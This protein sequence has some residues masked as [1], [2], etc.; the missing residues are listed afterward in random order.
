MIWYCSAFDFV[1]LM[2]FWKLKFLVH[3]MWCMK[4]KN[5]V[6]CIYKYTPMFN[7]VINLK[8]LFEMLSF[9]SIYLFPS[10][11]FKSFLCTLKIFFNLKNFLT[12]IYFNF[13]HPTWLLYLYLRCFDVTI[14]FFFK[15]YW[16]IVF[17]ITLL[18]LL[19]LMKET[20]ILLLLFNLTEYF[21]FVVYCRYNYTFCFQY[22]CL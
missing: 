4:I 22:I 18:V 11:F 3:I 15:F 13:F 12:T 1:F 7:F 9:Y 16:Q 10:Q 6:Y 21:W 17:F 5:Y 14:F 19:E 2:E 8:I 20:F